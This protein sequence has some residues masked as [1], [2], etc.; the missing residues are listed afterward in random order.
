MS[1]LEVSWIFPNS[2][3]SPFNSRLVSPV[4]LAAAHR[5]EHSDHRRVNRRGIIQQCMLVSAVTALEASSSAVETQTFRTWH[6]TITRATI[7]RSHGRH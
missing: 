2:R 1:G 5:T 3:P 7:S 4:S 6:V